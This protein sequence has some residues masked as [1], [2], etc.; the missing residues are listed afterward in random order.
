MWE[1]SADSRLEQRYRTYIQVRA[2]TAAAANNSR[3]WR[4]REIHQTPFKTAQFSSLMS[5]KTLRLRR[6]LKYLGLL[7]DFGRVYLHVVRSSHAAHFH[8]SADGCMMA[9]WGRLQAPQHP[10]FLCP[11]VGQSSSRRTLMLHV[12]LTERK[13]TLDQCTCVLSHLSC[14]CG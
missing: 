2:A 7:V 10:H 13:L 9:C 3:R 11:C 8:Q 14:V 4:G 12:Q 5:L 6:A 1:V